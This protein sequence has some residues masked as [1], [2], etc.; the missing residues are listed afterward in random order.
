[1]YP[2]PEDDESLLTLDPDV[3]GDDDELALRVDALLHADLVA[4]A[5]QAHV[6]MLQEVLREGIDEDSWKLVARIDEQILE[7]WADAVVSLA[8]FAFT[9]GRRFPLPKGEETSP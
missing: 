2:K 4:R 6:A 3:V 1:M 7:R 5:R 9:E 8:R